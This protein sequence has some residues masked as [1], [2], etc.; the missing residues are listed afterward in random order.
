[1]RI[2]IP[3][4]IYTDE[5]RVAATPPS[6]HKLIAL[7][8]EVTIESGA[9]EAAHYRDEAYEAVGASIA[10]DARSLWSTADFILKVR[11][12]MQNAALGKHEADLMKEGGF[13][14]SYCLLYTSDAAD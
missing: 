12:P 6:V 8:Y 11:A 2:G 1:M 5:R 14:I 7:G 9:G 3:K 10:A 13:L 4:E